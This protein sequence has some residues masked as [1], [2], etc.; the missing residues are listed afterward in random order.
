MINTDFFKPF[1]AQ[2]YEIYFLLLQKRMNGMN[3]GK[4]AVLALV[5]SWAIYGQERVRI[6]VKKGKK[7]VTF[8]GGP[9][10]GAFG[11]AKGYSPGGNPYR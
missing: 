6:P 9:S 8:G 7:T 5:A 2:K 11:G 4:A 10:Y 1:W 3:I